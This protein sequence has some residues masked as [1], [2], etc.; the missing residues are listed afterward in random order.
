M[1]TMIERVARAIDE[2][3]EWPAKTYRA[4]MAMAAIEAMR[5]PS[6]RMISEGESLASIGI[7]KPSDDEALPR[8]W[9]G[10]IDT[11]LNEKRP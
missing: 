6:E 7:G 2:C 1:T 8:V 4:R 11:A 3:Q 9:R 10:M 5:E